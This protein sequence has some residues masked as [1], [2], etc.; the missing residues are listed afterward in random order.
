MH[1]DA[2]I[3]TPTVTHCQNYLRDGVMRE[4]DSTETSETI[5]LVRRKPLH[6]LFTS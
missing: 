3:F 2:D 6:V 4:S 5:L 1:C